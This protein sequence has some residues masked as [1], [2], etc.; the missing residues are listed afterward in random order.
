MARIHGC[1]LVY[2]HVRVRG[3]LLNLTFYFM[4]ACQIDYGTSSSP[5]RVPKLPPSSSSLSSKP[6]PPIPPSSS[7]SASAAGMKPNSHPVTVLQ[8]ARHFSNTEVTIAHSRVVQGPSHYRYQH[9]EQEMQPSPYYHG[10]HGHGHGGRQQ[11]AGQQ[12]QRH[13]RHQYHLDQVSA[14][15]ANP[16]WS[17]DTQLR[18]EPAMEDPRHCVKVDKAQ[19]MC[20]IYTFTWGQ[21]SSNFF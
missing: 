14:I 21:G 8:N 11:V 12:Q 15:V 20:S 19:R 4:F 7:S 16:M 3:R 18:S 5:N 1:P 9:Q 2:I 13:H 10:Q 6:P 17:R